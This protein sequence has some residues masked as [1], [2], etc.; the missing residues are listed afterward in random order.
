MG[1]R[2]R[3]GSGSPLVIS[4]LNRSS[5]STTTDRGRG[6]LSRHL[7]YIL[8]KRSHT[9][10]QPGEETSDIYRPKK[11]NLGQRKSAWRS[12]NWK[13]PI[14]RWSQRRTTMNESQGRE[15]NRADDPT[16]KEQQSR[17]INTFTEEQRDDGS[18][19][20]LCSSQRTP[21]THCHFLILTSVIT[22]QSGKH[23]VN[24][25]LRKKKCN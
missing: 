9:P 7:T 6:S 20:A 3:G 22:D 19:W 1:R 8:G 5:I 14:R 15:K 25:W 4:T 16:A 23:W 11:T 21:I 24:C 17:T 2:Q 10:T 18:C 13:W 12:P